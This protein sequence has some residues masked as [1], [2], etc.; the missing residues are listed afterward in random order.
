MDKSGY[1]GRLLKLKL[2]PLSVYAEIYDLLLL[3]SLD[4][5]EY[6]VEIENMKRRNESNTRQNS[7][8]EFEIKNNRLAKA[9][10]K[11][12]HQTKHLYNIVSRV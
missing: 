8:D 7:R 2:L 12:F 5:N 9:D 10:E 6:D 4:W 3:I 1:K 11:F